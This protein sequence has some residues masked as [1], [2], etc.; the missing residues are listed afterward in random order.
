VIN[1][2]ELPRSIAFVVAG[3]AGAATPSGNLTIQEIVPQ[4]ATWIFPQV[5]PPLNVVAIL[6]GGIGIYATKFRL[7]GPD[8]REI[9]VTNGPDVPFTTQIKRS[10]LIVPLTSISAEPVVASAGLYYIDLLIREQTI[11]STPLDIVALPAPPPGFN[12]PSHPT[13]PQGG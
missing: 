8:G 5:L 1:S 13:P 12:F 11:A 9:A 3:G 7:T 4:I 10:N 6:L 2:P